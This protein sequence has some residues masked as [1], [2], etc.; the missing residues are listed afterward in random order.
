MSDRYSWLYIRLILISPIFMQRCKYNSKEERRSISMRSLCHELWWN[1]VERSKNTKYTIFE[2]F[3]KVLSKSFSSFL[4]RTSSK[5]IN[6]SIVF[7]RFILQYYCYD[8]YLFVIST[9][10][11]N[12]KNIQM[13]KKKK[14]RN[15]HSWNWKNK[16]Y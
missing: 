10:I 9:I 6:S 13:K 3:G 2:Y 5:I 11:I 4:R 16:E 15:A 1:V 14:I 12:Y 8:R 7:P